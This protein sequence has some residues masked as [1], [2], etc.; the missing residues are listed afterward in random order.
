MFI[1]FEGVEGSSKTTQATL[2][3]N[4]L[5]SLGIDHVLTKEP[6]TSNVNVCKK[7]REIILNPLN[8]MSRRTEFFLYLADRAEHVEKC[9]EPALRLG[10]WVISD[11]Y[12]DSTK[13]YQ[14]V[15]RNLG[16]DTISPM[17]E[18]ATRG[19]MPDLT[20]IMDVPV[21][22]GLRR[23]MSS[24]KEFSGGD[25][26]ERESIDFHNSL[27]QGFLDIACVNDR[28]VV[29]DASRSIEELSADVVNILDPYVKQYRRN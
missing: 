17:I 14:G 20:F 4:R 25:R 5:T 23:A 15:G 7:I 9:I 11:R 29:L 19:I 28:Y 21:E 22:I 27:R 13:I 18:Y 8:D 16:V 26:M 1:T 12:F 24:N 2:L 10:R 3:S 6:G